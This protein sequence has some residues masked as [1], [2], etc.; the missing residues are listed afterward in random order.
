MARNT[1]EECH[2]VE[3]IAEYKLKG[4]LVD[5][6]SSSDPGKQA[7]DPSKRQLSESNCKDLYPTHSATSDKTVNTLVLRSK[8]VL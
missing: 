8:V 5:A 3:N 2:R 4:E 6:E 7:I 1:N